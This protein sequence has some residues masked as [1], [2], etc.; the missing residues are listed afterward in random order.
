MPELPPEKK[1]IKNIVKSY[2]NDN[3]NYGKF[4]FK[5]MFKKNIESIS[6]QFFNI[7]AYYFDKYDAVYFHNRMKGQYVLTV[8]SRD[9]IE[10]TKQVTLLGFDFVGDWKKFHR[11]KFAVFIKLARA[12]KAWYVFDEQKIFDTLMRI[13]Q[14][15]GWSLDEREKTSVRQTVR[16]LYNIL[17]LNWDS[18]W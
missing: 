16:R 1:E 12:N 17:Y 13:M 18:P 3:N 4:S 8:K 11:A 7:L 2:F 10:P 5:G 9:G 15:K 6:N 14:E